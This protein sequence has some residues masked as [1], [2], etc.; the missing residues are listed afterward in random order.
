[1]SR[2]MSDFDLR[3]L[4]KFFKGYFLVAIC[5]EEIENWFSMFSLDIVFGFDFT[6]VMNEILE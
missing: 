4:D 2:V 6:E 5:V 1:M 3:N